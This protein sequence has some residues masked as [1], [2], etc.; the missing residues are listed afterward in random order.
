MRSILALARHEYRAA[1]RS[2]VLAPLVVIMV[3]VTAVSVYVGAAAFRSQL[4]DYRAYRAAAQ[5]SGVLRVAPSPLAVLALLR[6]ALEYVEIV[7]AVFAIALGYLSVSRERTSRTLALIRSRPVTSAQLA[8]GSLLGAIAVIV[9]LV[10]LTAA[11]SVACLGLIGH[12]WIGGT[13]ALKLALACTAAVVYM[14]AFYCLGA[15]ITAKCRVP[16][17]GLMIALGLWLLVVLIL[18]QLGDTLDPDNQVPGGLFAALALNPAQQL[19]IQ[20]HLG[21]YEHV[22][23]TLE[24]VSFEKHFER[25]A[26]AMIDIKDNRRGFGLMRL[27]AITRTDLA[28]IV[29]YATALV[30]AFKRTFRHQPTV[31]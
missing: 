24:A 19:Q 2:R 29:F 16:V 22:R 14:T 20:A 11:A 23:T 21:I 28:W 8:A 13:D 4:A 15:A 25:F 3:A 5:A 7:G 12:D 6:G 31:S 1:T 26:F 17:N 27:L 10:A 9:T 30:G 18:P